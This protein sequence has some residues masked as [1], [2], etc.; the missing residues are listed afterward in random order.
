M[1]RLVIVRVTTA[2]DWGEE[3]EE[4]VQGGADEAKKYHWGNS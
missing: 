1:V 3:G 2:S 4:Q